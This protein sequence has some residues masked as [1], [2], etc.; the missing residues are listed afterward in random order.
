MR[1]MNYPVL[2][3][4]CTVAV[5]SVGLALKQAVEAV[6][7]LIEELLVVL[8][9]NDASLLLIVF[10]LYVVL[11]LWRIY[12]ADFRLHSHCLDSVEFCLGW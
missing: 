6:E 12:V 4:I 11:E 9:A 10:V 2:D 5:F 1:Y 8:E 7:E 3:C